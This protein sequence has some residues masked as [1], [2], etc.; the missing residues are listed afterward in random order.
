MKSP[1]YHLT[2]L[3]HSSG[4]DHDFGLFSSLIKAK[5]RARLES[6]RERISWT[7]DAPGMWT[8]LD[9]E[10]DYY[11]ISQRHVW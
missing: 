4:I 2:V 8:F 10:D 5:A 7:N 1:I 3:S 6:G 9:N 11:M